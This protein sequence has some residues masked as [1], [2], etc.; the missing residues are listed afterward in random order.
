MTLIEV[1]GSDGT[2]IG[3]CDS[4]C[5]E[6][7]GGVCLCVCGGLNHGKGLHGALVGLMGVVERIIAG[8]CAQ[9]S[10]SVGIKVQ[11]ALP[12]GFRCQADSSQI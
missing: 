1:V 2:L 4:N 5:Y 3:R 9:E 11:F 12:L 8:G 7:I 10:G 6:A